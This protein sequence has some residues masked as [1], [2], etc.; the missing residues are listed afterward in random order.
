MSVT[1]RVPTVLRPQAAGNATVE[2]EGSTLAEVVA[3][4]E[5]R[6]PGFSGTLLDDSGGLKRFVNVFVGEE[7]VRHLEG[8]ETA[9]PDGS[10]IVILPAVAGG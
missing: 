4:M 9:V 2:V 7:D 10:E 5:D 6:F 3:A 1:V 8:L